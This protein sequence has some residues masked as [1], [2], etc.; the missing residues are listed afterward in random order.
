M[1]S[2]LAPRTSRRSRVIAVIIAAVVV[3]L[4]SG[5]GGASTKKAK[6]PTSLEAPRAANELAFRFDGDDEGATASAA[7][8]YVKEALIQAGYRLDEGEAAETDATFEVRVDA[9]ERQSLLKM[10]VNGKELVSYDFT[11]TLA[12]S[13][14]GRTGDQ[15]SVRFSGG[16]GEI[17]QQALDL[18]VPQLNGSKRFARFCES[19]RAAQA[20]RLVQAKEA[21]AAE[22]REATEQAR[23]EQEHAWAAAGVVQCT[24]P[25]SLTA[26]D[27]VRAY[28][29]KWPQG[30]HAAEGRS[31]LH[32]AEP[33]LV[34]LQRDEKQWLASDARSCGAKKVRAECAGVE[35][36][37]TKFPAGM[38]AAEAKALIE[39]LE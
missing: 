35:L 8:E 10:Q 30:P 36:Y 33:K 34:E 12:A 7:S 22:E 13:D 14:D 19:A 31:A 32:D 20:T 26:C 37:L 4:G 3:T 6:G 2:L 17:D 1:R 16:D 21:A 18:L 27:G 38:H 9:V 25:T 5:C 24:N 11:V 29:A 28:L 39:G 23:V 15:H